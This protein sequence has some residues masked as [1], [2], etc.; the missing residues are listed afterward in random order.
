MRSAAEGE[1][2][3]GEERLDG[4]ARRRAIL[5]E[6]WAIGTRWNGAWCAA[7]PKS[8]V[9]SSRPSLSRAKVLTSPSAALDSQAAPPRGRPTWSAG[10][11][12]AARSA[13][14]RGGVR[15][16]SP[17]GRDRT[18]GSMRSTTARPEGS[19]RGRRPSQPPAGRRARLH[20]RT[21][22]RSGANALAPC[23]SA[24]SLQSR[25]YPC[26]ARTRC[27]G[28]RTSCRRPGSSPNP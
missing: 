3:T 20:V 27:T 25:S 4:I 17:Q 15:D 19:A 12:S 22:H 23:A 6:R 2:R 16:R 24:A 5:P 13:A 10:R 18:A 9:A 14:R 21:H 28:G 7:A 8:G 1:H 26:P 11:A